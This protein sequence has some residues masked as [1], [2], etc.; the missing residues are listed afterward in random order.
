MHKRWVYGSNGNSHSIV[1]HVKKY[2]TCNS[3][4]GFSKYEF[5]NKLLGDVTL[6]R[7]TSGVTW[8][9]LIYIYIYIS[10]ITSINIF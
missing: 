8:T 2:R 5:Y 10:N 9:Q 4:M 6:F 1:M 7:I 3:T